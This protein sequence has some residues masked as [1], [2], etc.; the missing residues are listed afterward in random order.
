MSYRS[1]L[2]TSISPL[3]SSVLSSFTLKYVCINIF[4][5]L[6]VPSHINH[7]SI[8]PHRS[9][10]TRSAEN[11]V[12]LRIFLTERCNLRCELPL[13][14]LINSGLNAYS[15]YLLGFYYMSSEGV[16]LSPNGK[17]PTNEEI[18]RL[19]TLVCEIWV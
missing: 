3:A 8:L 6:K 17:L 11:I 12:Y 13:L 16:E 14:T 19:T 7:R 15:V 10:S 1:L 9:R 4:S 2:V 18:L 5:E